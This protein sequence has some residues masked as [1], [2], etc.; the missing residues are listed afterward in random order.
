MREL[1]LRS[2]VHSDIHFLNQIIH[3]RGVAPYAQEIAPQQPF[4]GQYFCGEEPLVDAA[5][6]P[7]K[8]LKPVLAT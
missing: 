8:I 3:F 4:M 7:L 5:K 6:H 2:L 1:A